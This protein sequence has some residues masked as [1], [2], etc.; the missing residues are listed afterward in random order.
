VLDDFTDGPSTIIVPPGEKEVTPQRTAGSMAGEERTLWLSKMDPSVQATLSVANPSHLNFAGPH[1]SLKVAW[2]ETHPLGLALGPGS[3]FRVNLGA[4]TNLIWAEVIVFGPGNKR[5]DSTRSYA[6]PPP[7]GAP[8]V[9]PLAG[10]TSI[11]DVPTIDVV[12]VL[13]DAN[14]RLEVT[15]VDIT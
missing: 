11:G 4:A 7:A 10:F 1:S 13:F 9:F 6:N 15:S 3:A 14:G 2:G 8:L 5:A 12:Y